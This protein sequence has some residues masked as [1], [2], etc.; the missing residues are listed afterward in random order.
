[1]WQGRGGVFHGWHRPSKFVTYTVNL[2]LKVRAYKYLLSS[3]AAGMSM[4]NQNEAIETSARVA[5]V[6]A[7]CEGKLLKGLACLSLTTWP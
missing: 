7:I 6:S 3:H 4:L 2:H 1:M 5:R